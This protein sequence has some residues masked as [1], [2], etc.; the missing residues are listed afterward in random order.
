M[1]SK[2]S[3]YDNGKTKFQMPLGRNSYWIRWQLEQKIRVK[4]IIETVGG[5]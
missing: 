5:G 1:L 2:E 4:M 3:K